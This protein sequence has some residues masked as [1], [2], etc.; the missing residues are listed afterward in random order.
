[1]IS[2]TNEYR[3][4]HFNN[5]L[6]NPGFPFADLCQLH[7]HFILELPVC[8]SHLVSVTTDMSKIRAK[9]FSIY[10]ICLYYIIEFRIYFYNS[11]RTFENLIANVFTNSMRRS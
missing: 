5:C 4:M 8:I 10:R 1:M 9:V 11:N 7:L 6:S 3:L 2:Q